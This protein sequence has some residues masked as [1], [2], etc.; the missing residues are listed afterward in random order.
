VSI[1]GAIAIAATLGAGCSCGET[2]RRPP[3][4]RDADGGT[5][6]GETGA[7]CSDGID[8]DSD[9]L[10]DCA[11][12]S[13]L[14]APGCS[15]DGGPRI[16][17]GFG[18]C[19]AF[20][21]EAE[22]GLAPVDIVWIIDNSGSMDEET[23]LIQDNLNAFAASL[24]SSGIEDYR[25]IVITDPAAFGLSVPAPLGVDAERFLLVA[26]DVQSHDALSDLIETL[27]S[28]MPFLR[29]D[30]IKHIVHVTDDESNMG[31]EELRTTLTAS[32]GMFTSHAIA[33]PPGE[34]HCPLDSFCP[35]F[36]EQDGCTGPH[37]EAEDNGDEYWA[38]SMATGG[39]QLS[40]CS[41]DWSVV[42]GTLERSIAVPMPIPCEFEIPDPP[43][44]MT[45]D[46]HRVN[47]RYSPGSGGASETFP[48]VGT[49]DGAACPPGGIGWYYDDATAPTEIRLCPSTC[50]RVEEDEGRVDI[51]L[52]CE[53]IFG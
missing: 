11:E 18:G 31:W 10:V 12:S 29:T 25:V 37:G 35:P 47:V 15:H 2:R 46:R 13:C 49:D 45:F 21:F 40:I 1:S 9:G 17:A 20:A 30:S 26:H 24:T 22:E 52:G 4:E 28:W 8:N 27:P 44:G 43:D 33:S 48:Y 23:V 36:P 6:G 32:I 39:V 38:L 14:G 3:G 16:D 51:E 5:V 19:E 41:A 42:F 50:T 53:T 7:Q 34:R